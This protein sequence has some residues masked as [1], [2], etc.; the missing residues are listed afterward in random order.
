MTWS[1]LAHSSSAVSLYWP[2]T[3]SRHP[4]LRSKWNNWRKVMSQ[5][6]LYT[7]AWCTKRPPPFE[8]RGKKKQNDATGPFNTATLHQYMGHMLSETIWRIGCEWMWWML[9]KGSYMIYMTSQVDISFFFAGGWKTMTKRLYILNLEFTSD[10]TWK[11]N[12][13][14]ITI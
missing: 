6:M 1:F 10:T 3:K 13:V 2:P 12:S 8:T 9:V 5:S 4:I 11:K 7:Q 14:W